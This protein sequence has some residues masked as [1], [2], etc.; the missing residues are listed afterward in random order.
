M[1]YSC[2][3]LGLVMLL[4][5]M[6]PASAVTMAWTPIGNPGNP[7]DTL[8]MVDDGTTGYGSVP[9][10]YSIGTYEVTNAQYADFLNAKAKSDPLGLYDPKMADPTYHSVG[11]PFRVLDAGLGGITRDGT[12]GSY[13]YSAIA[14]RENL[15]V[16]YV[17]FYDTLRFANWMNNGQGNGNTETGA[18]SLLGGTPV[19]SNHL[20]LSRNIGATIVLPSEDEWYKAA[21]YDAGSS[22]YFVDP[23]GS[24]SSANCTDGHPTA[25]P[26]SANCESNPFDEIQLPTNVGSYPNS[27]S[28]YGTY[29][30]G[31][32]IA[33]V[34]EHGGSR[35]IVSRSFPSDPRESTWIW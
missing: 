26:N 10:N 25:T 7:A 11:F 8:V 17:S 22:H 24:D 1:R 15:P 27:A 16:N 14:G 29:D 28:P 4:L 19:P 3:R 32:N 23:M 33:E 6:S 34:N 35:W 9:Y 31:G 20:T 12:S 13:T 5:F 21:Y 30:Q 18:Y 2:A